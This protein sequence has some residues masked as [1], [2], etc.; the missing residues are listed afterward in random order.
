MLD[1]KSADKQKH[2][3]CQRDDYTIFFTVKFKQK[4]HALILSTFSNL[5]T[6]YYYLESKHICYLTTKNSQAF[7]SVSQ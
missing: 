4:L 7:F 3:I 2:N 1:C 5:H 6:L